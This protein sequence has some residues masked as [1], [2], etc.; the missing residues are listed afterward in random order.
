MSGANLDAYSTPKDGIHK[1]EMQKQIDFLEAQ[2][3]EI[4]AQMIELKELMYKLIEK[5]ENTDDGK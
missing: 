1:L 4:A 5:I 3:F 2:T